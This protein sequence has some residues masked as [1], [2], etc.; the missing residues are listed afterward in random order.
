MLLKG[1]TGD[2]KKAST[3]AREAFFL[4]FA[5]VVRERFKDV[6]L[7]V[8]GGFRTRKG[9]EAALE[10]GACD[11]IGLGRPAVL[12]PSLPNSLLLNPEVSDADARVYTRSI[13][14]PWIAKVVNITAVTGG[15]ETVS[16]V[17]PV[18]L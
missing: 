3:L 2:T 9:M 1:G 10:G 14:T 8:T 11:L 13:P 16:V 6:P 7:M 5:Q 15:A 4:D 17:I 12:N 18:L